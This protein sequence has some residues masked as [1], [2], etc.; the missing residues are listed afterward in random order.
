[1]QRK[2]TRVAIAQEAEPQL[3]GLGSKWRAGGR[4]VVSA[5]ERSWG[6]GD[7]LGEERVKGGASPTNTRTHFLLRPGHTRFPGT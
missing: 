2:Q 5:G 7:R 1:M 4:G 3:V 6:R